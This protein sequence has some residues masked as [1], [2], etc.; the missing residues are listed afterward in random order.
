VGKVKYGVTPWGAWFL[1]M[2]QAY[3]GTGRI[4]RGKTYANTGRV[5]DIKVKGQIVT[6]KVAGRDSAYYT[7]RINFPPLSKKIERQVAQ[8]LANNP[9]ALVALR[10]GIMQD[11]L[12]A[13]FEKNDVR[14]LPARWIKSNAYCSCP[15]DGNPCKHIAAVLFILSR[16]I[17]FD[18]RLIFS[19]AGF[20]LTQNFDDNATIDR[21]KTAVCKTES[22]VNF[23]QPIPAAIKNK[24]T[25]SEILQTEK[26]SH[27]ILNFA[28]GE[29]YLPLIT[30]FLPPSPIFSHSNL[31]IKLTEAYHTALFAYEFNFYGEKISDD[32][33]DALYANVSVSSGGLAKTEDGFPLKNN[34]PIT[35]K[36]NFSKTN[37]AECT[38]LKAGK[39]FDKKP[40]ADSGCTE[41]YACAFSFYRL[42]KKLIWDSAFIP[43]VNIHAQKL[44]L[45][46]KPLTASTEINN[47]IDE[48]A[49]CLTESFFAPVKTWGKRYCAELLLTAYLT[50]Y[51][52]G[53]GFMPRTSSANDKIIDR[54]FFAG[55]QIST[56]IPGNKN[57]ATAIYTWLA[58]LNYQPN[59]YFYRL[60]V[61]SKI[62]TGE[63]SDETETLKLSASVTKLDE[64]NASYIDLPVAIRQASEAERER[65]LQFPIVLSSY[66]PA[67]TELAVKSH[68]TL[69]LNAAAD[70][71]QSAAKLLQKFGVEI[72]LPKGLQKAL[73]PKAVISVKATGKSKAVQSFFTRESFFEYDYKI[74]IGEFELSVDE[75]R[76]MVN[77][78][79][80]LI[81]FRDQY[82]LL[83]PDEVAKLF[84]RLEN[85]KP[86]SQLDIMQAVLADEAVVDK[87]AKVH[88]DKIFK[89]E[90]LSEPKKLQATLRP[91][92]QKGFSWMYANIK[93]GLGCLLADDMGLGKT[94]QV[95]A[96]ILTLQEQGE[97]HSEAGN[98]VLIVCPA[99]LLSNWKHEIRKF[100]PSLSCDVYHGAGRKISKA[101]ITLTTYQTMQKDVAAI[102]NASFCGIIL[103]EAQAIKNSAAKTSKAIKQPNPKFKIALTGT[104][105]ENSLEDVRSIFDFILPGYFGDAKTF[106]EKWRIPIELHA[107][108]DVSEQFAKI[109]APFILRRLKTDKAII[110]D[111]PEKVLS[112][113]YCNLTPQQAAMYE[114]LIQNELVPALEAKTQAARTTLILK[115]LTGLKQ[116]CNHPNAFDK[117]SEPASELSGKTQSLC[118]LLKDV[119]AGGEKVIIFSQYVQTINILESIIQNELKTFS[120]KITGRMTQMQRAENVE[121]FQTNPQYRVMLISLKAGGT[122][123]NL[124]A[125]SRVIHF[126]L[127]Y[128]PA[129]E[130]QATDRAF[131][132]GQTRNVFVH[133]FICEGTFE[134]KIDEMIQK[135]RSIAESISGGETWISKLSNAEL[136]E[137]LML[138]K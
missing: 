50:E 11:D 85:E 56:K 47:A 86:L 28:S 112:N 1:R 89:T 17:D 37:V 99:T 124:T 69:D 119:L 71:L 101:D 66:L 70:F 4:T 113:T 51:V 6:A 96:L 9:I 45:F 105:V 23:E 79:S 64:M 2:L 12:I 72:V 5:E 128:N 46:W 95:I 111:L 73:T 43:A 134:E 116:V 54:L 76:K 131:R 63:E 42:A 48:F 25:I 102:S 36:I 35:L 126:D 7:V 15:D 125:A 136:K 106:R 121:L 52:F 82:V 93:S 8:I 132:I 138:E 19:I 129:V 78:N 133:R 22:C 81:K 135:K 24:K 14:L 92:Q 29:S 40:S 16:E 62:G 104:P 33:A 74:M 75:F 31:I 77:K 58:V 27:A 90:I 120:L 137:I 107:N 49:A 80:K 130:D 60:T 94:L 26:S 100:A 20:D 21:T 97:L 39:F 10:S 41:S 57:L 118:L 123:L 109:T 110:S 68:I 61:K 103:D 53:L 65:I 30:G 127:W 13:E 91:Y 34:V 84:A 117:T 3:D 88:T 59:E 114:A 87:S 38:L 44:S 67:M 115:L 122:G 55:E 98:G 32:Y 18:P 108:A 83:N